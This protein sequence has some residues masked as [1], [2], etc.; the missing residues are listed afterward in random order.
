LLSARLKSLERAG[1]VERTTNGKNVS[2]RLTESGEELKP[3]IMQLGV[4][5]H[6]WARS[7]LSTDDLDPSGACPPGWARITSQM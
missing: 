4:W 3:I 6:R 2:Y 5:G 1:V 7:D